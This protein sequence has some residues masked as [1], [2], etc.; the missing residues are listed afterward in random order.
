VLFYCWGVGGGAGGGFDAVAEGAWHHAVAIPA[1][2]AKVNKTKTADSIL[3]FAPPRLIAA[4]YQASPA[5][6]LKWAALAAAI[7]ATLRSLDGGVDEDMRMGGGAAE[8][9]AADAA[10]QRLA[11]IQVRVAPAPAAAAHPPGGAAIDV[12]RA[13]RLAHYQ[14]VV[15]P[16]ADAA[17]VESAGLRAA[18]AAAF[19]ARLH[20]APPLAA[21]RPAVEPF[22]GLGALGPSAIARAA[23]AQ[24][25]QQKP[26]LNLYRGGTAHGA[27]L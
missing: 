19:R 5:D 15:E 23:A 8:P 4:A 16:D 27:A 10:Q 25:L 21:A 20:V 22:A 6:V 18:R 9:R 26:G 12:A 24:V 17:R 13:A 7:R 14:S 2:A 1:A 3:A 11:R